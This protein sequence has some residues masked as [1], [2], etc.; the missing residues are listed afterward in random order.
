MGNKNDKV[1]GDKNAGNKGKTE[2]ESINL[3]KAS[4]ISS[5]G[6]FV[7][8]IVNIFV[9]KIKISTFYSVLIIVWIIFF[10]MLIIKVIKKQMITS[11][12]AKLNLAV[13]AIVIVISLYSMIWNGITFHPPD[14][15]PV[16][17]GTAVQT[18]TIQPPTS[19]YTSTLTLTPTLTP[20]PTST[21]TNYVIN[22]C[23]FDLGLDENNEPIVK[24][25]VDNLERL[26]FNVKI[27]NIDEKSSY[28]GCEVL[29]LSDGWISLRSLLIDQTY[30]NQVMDKMSE[31]GG[32]G[33]LIGNPGKNYGTYTLKFY[34]DITFSSLS[35]EEIAKMG[36]SKIYVDS[37][38]DL[39][40]ALLKDIGD[41]DEDKEMLPEP[42]SQVVPIES[43][44]KSYWPLVVNENYHYYALVSSGITGPRYLIMPGGEFS[45]ADPIPDY[46]YERFIKWLARIPIN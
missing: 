11:T 9:G 41:S 40:H 1:V 32:P 10:V 8:S 29:Y 26:G 7:L 22:V 35:T 25:N 5:I 4:H 21:P 37:E 12:F 2:K 18:E 23:V 13:S 17:N 42:E 14:P 3:T 45:S 15:T 39:Y 19:T 28:E 34:D 27:I 36:S 24:T 38:S 46:L 30:L 20:T 16:P 44:T 43:A 6:S 33:L 31:Y